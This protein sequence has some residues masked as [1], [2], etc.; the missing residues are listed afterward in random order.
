MNL[1]LALMLQLT[2]LLPLLATL[3]IAATGQKPNL[4]E[5]ITISISLVVLYC[6]VNLYHALKAGASIAVSWWELIPGLEISF[7]VEPLGMLFALIASFLW[8]ITTIYAIGYMRGHGEDNQTRFYLCFALAISAVMG[9]AFSANLFTLFVFYEV[10][11][12]STYPLVT[13]AGT[14]KAKKGGRVYLGILLSTSIAFFLLAIILTWFVAGSLEFKSGGVFGPSV[15]TGLV[16][17][18]LVLF[19]FGIGKA[20]IMPFHRW[21]PA[22]MV[23]PTPVSALLHAVAVVKAGVF[24]VLKICIFIFGLDLLPSLPTTEFLLYLASISV[25]LASI[26]AMRQDNLKARLAYSTVSQLGYITIGA[27]LA[28]SSGVIGSSMHIAT[29]AFGKITLFFCA[30]AILVA[31]HKSKVS[32]M[33]GLGFTMPVTMAAF[34]IASLSIIGVPP[35]GGTWSKWFLLM[36]TMETGYWSIMMVLMLSSLLNI[37]YLLPIPYHAFFPGK[38]HSP[39]KAGLKEAPLPSLIALSITTLGCLLLFI[40]PQPF[41]ELA[42]AILTVPG[43]SHEQ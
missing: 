10:L 32:E 39:T 26:V 9:L 23:A 34:F 38:E 36:G 2:I 24:T 27:L 13:H 29:H 1:S 20:A 28:T 8:L 19:V 31:A 16:G 3:A 30:G 5:A 22:A 40:Y 11:T 42:N 33:R 43:V 35:A 37:A 18:I 12:L 7:V 14:D 4:R 6:V 21:L 41:Y 15:D 25:L 17:A